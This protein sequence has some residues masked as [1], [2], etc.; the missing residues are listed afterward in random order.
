MAVTR[1]QG[2]L[3]NTGHPT[4]RSQSD[5]VAME[6]SFLL[7]R[8]FYCTLGYACLYAASPFAAQRLVW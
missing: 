2:P 7:F 5:I 3:R 1:L 6:K 8:T 4:W